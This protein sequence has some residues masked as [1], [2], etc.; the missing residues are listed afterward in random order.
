MDNLIQLAY[1]KFACEYSKKNW[2]CN[3]PNWDQ[4]SESTQKFWTEF[5]KGIVNNFEPEE[6]EEEK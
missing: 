5:V 1:S 4:L 3:C 2:I 6:G